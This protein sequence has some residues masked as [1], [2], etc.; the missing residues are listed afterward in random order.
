LVRPGENAALATRVAFANNQ[1]AMMPRSAAI[2]APARMPAGQRREH[3]LE[4][5][6][7]VILDQGFEALTM[8]SLA[9]NAGVSKGLGYAYFQNAEELALELF[10]REVAQMYGEVADA[11][12]SAVDIADR[13]RRGV[14]KYLDVVGERGALLTLLQTKLS[15]RKRRRSVRERLRPMFKLWRDLVASQFQV[16]PSDAEAI[17][18]MMLSAS[19]AMA[20]AWRA[21]R[22]SRREAEDLCVAFILSGM[23]GAATAGK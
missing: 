23:R 3:L 14:S 22:I 21:K 1:H 17:T 13:V 15:G 9:A 2:R 7:R 4:A 11:I 18:G 6:A 5:A 19:D 12:N 8:E 16:S 10:D 20:R